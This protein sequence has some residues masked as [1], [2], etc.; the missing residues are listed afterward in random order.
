MWQGDIQ[1]VRKIPVNEENPERF[2]P[3]CSVVICTHDRPNELEH[4]LEAVS[5]LRYRRFV[6]LVVDNASTDSQASQVAARWGARY[7]VEPSECVV[8]FELFHRSRPPQKLLS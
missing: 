7:L 4:C 1:K 5:R 3:T 2:E 8:Q 6:V